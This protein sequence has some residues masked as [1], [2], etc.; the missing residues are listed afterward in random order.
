MNNQE[1]SNDMDTLV[2]DAQTLLNATV[3]VAEEKV[4]EAR[5]RLAT[6]LSSGQGVLDRFRE[7]AAEGAKA[8]DQIVSEHPYETIG[9]AFGLGALLG[10]L[11]TRRN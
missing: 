6:A 5:K 8:A 9:I 1:I 3:D 7:K 4:V 2:K 11:L 10:F